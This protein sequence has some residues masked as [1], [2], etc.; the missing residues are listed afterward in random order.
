VKSNRPSAA[1]CRKVECQ[2]LI[3]HA[4]GNAPVCN[5]TCT[6]PGNLGACPLGKIPY[7]EVISV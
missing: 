7:R 4:Q 6:I 5:L 1:E 3:E 2:E